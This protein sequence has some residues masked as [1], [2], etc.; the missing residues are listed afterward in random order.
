[1]ERLAPSQVGKGGFAQAMRLA[2]VIGLGGGFLY[3]Y[4]RS[5][6]TCPFPRQSYPVSPPDMGIQPLAGWARRPLMRKEKN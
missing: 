1:M 2:G 6:R 5:A 3:F 4:Q